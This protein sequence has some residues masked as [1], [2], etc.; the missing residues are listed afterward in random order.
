MSSPPAHRVEIIRELLRKYDYH[1]Y[2]LNESLVSDF[3]YDKLFDE[4]IKLETENPHLITN[5]SPSQRVGS[6]ITKEFKSITHQKQMLSLAN[7]YSYDELKEFD[8]RVKKSLPNLEKVEYVCELKIDGLSISINYEDGIL[9]YAATRGDGTVGEDVTN[10]IRTI[11]SLPL[12]INS[13][14][15]QKL[16]LRNFEVRGEIYFE[17]EAFNQLNK[18]RELQGEKVF[19]NPRNSAAGTVKLQDPK[20]VAKRPLRIFT[21]YISTNEYRIKS[22][23]E[24]LSLLKELGFTINKN[25]EVCSGIE[26]VIKFCEKWEVLRDTLPYEIDGVVIKVNSLDYQN[27]LGTSAKWPSWA[28]A[29]KFTAQ[30]KITLLNAITWQVG[31]TGTITPVAE[32]EPVL[33]AGST[34]SRATLHNVDEIK[35]KDIRVGDYV[36]IEKGGDVIPKVVGIVLEKRNPDIEPLEI[37][38]NCPVCSSAL[39]R[40]EE[41]VALVCPNYFCPAQI[42]GRLI[43]F[44]SRGAMNIEG[45]GDA[46]IELLV[47]NGFLNDFSDIYTLKNRKE[48]LLKIE[49]LG[50]K[51]INNLLKSIESS[52]ERPFSKVLFGLGIR[53]VGSVA[54]QKLSENFSSISK[55]IH[56]SQEQIEEI[57]EIG[58]SI[59]ASVKKYFSDPRN[60]ELINKL[61][62]AGLKFETGIQSVKSQKFLGK[63][64]VVTG[65]LSKYSREQVKV[66]II[67]N[68]GKVVSSVSKNTNYLVMGENPGSKYDQAKKLNIEIINED[69]FIKLIEQ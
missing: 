43:H 34:I 51:S 6:D 4:L 29:F 1:Y 44:S 65:T 50:E 41:E 14:A 36:K 47:D 48:E 53:Y 13:D 16:N 17:L 23:S 35:R 61:I 28:V 33:L 40:N 12:R 9:N 63:S 37:P 49:R 24:N 54:A 39:T 68:G 7:T 66:I 32:L 55:L 22:Q 10:N 25:Y 57:H 5:D 3:E 59:S 58:P 45:L 27:I 62:E 46:L 8:K 69:E 11:K 67:E 19:A 26:E 60:I 38:N 56:A 2:I 21:Y 52:K 15:S 42:K 64:F 20:L 18:E 30:Q 31:R